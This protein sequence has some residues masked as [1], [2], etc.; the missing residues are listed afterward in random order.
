MQP[1]RAESRALGLHNLPSRL[2]LATIALGSQCLPS[3][4]NVSMFQ[5]VKHRG[6]GEAESAFVI[7]AD[8][9]A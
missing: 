8:A 4:F 2:N 6:A 7:V 5:V 1:E 3:R 9:V